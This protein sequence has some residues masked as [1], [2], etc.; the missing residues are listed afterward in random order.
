MSEFDFDLLS[1][2]LIRAAPCG[3]LSLPGVLAALARDEVESFPALRPHQAPAWRMFLG[4]IGALALHRGETTEPP[5]DEP[6][7]RDLLRALAPEFPHDEPWRL[8]VD[9][10]TKPAFLQPPVPKGVTLSNN[11]ETPDALDLLITSRNHDLKQA[12]ARRADPEDWIFALVSL[13]TGEG[14]GGATNYGIARMNGGSSSRTMMALAPAP[15]GKGVTP[16]LGACFHRDIRALRESRER[17]LAANDHLG[18]PAE[19]GLA[20]IWVVP[21]PEGEQ[22]PLSELDIWFVEVCRRIRLRENAGKISAAKG[23]SKATRIDAKAF[24]GVLGDPYAPVHKTEGKSFTLGEGD[25]D[26]RR[27]TDLLLSGDW[28][29]PVLARLASFDRETLTL[30][31]S[32]LSRGNSKTDGFKTRSLPL[33]GKVV[34]AIGPRQAELFQLARDQMGAIDAADKALAGALAL[35]AAG[36]D[37]DKIKKET[38]SYASA[39]RAALDRAADTVFFE[40]LWARFAAQELGDL[41]LEAEQRRFARF[42]RGEAERVFEAALPTMPCAA[43]FR[44]RAEARARLAFFGALRN[45]LPEGFPQPVDE[46]EADA[47]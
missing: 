34:Q 10:R 12:V 30:V 29:L 24:K 44:L 31:C 5:Q 7:W 20:L 43:A 27:V 11:V 42:L 19:G 36:G 2:A 15:G 32:A 17:E 33:S 9:D 47:A 23:T 4:Q 26:Y 1:E 45:A 3:T 13:Q 14:F 8:V 40:H 22:I 38:Y 21:W 37:R 25:F 6:A 18:F 28:R 46:D 16:R 39:A 41:A 35:A